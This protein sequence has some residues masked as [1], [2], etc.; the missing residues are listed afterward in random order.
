MSLPEHN[1]L[2]GGEPGAGKSVALS[3]LVA[4]AALDPAVTL[5]L[6][7]GKRVELATWEPCA[8]RLVGP[9]LEEAL[10]VLDQLREEMDLVTGSFSRRSAGRCRL[11]TASDCNWSSSTSWPC[12]WRLVIAGCEKASRSRCAT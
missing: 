8:A 4:A 9:S 1:V 3:L 2:I 7:D 12:T 11:R 5:W 6:L 10:G